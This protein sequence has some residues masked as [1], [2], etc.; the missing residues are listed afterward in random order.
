MR[1]LGPLATGEDLAPLAPILH[2]WMHLL[3]F[4]LFDAA[5]LQGVS[6]PIIPS[7]DRRGPIF[8]SRPTWTWIGPGILMPDRV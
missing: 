1:S 7:I 3:E 4:D 8:I 6:P 2:R 5:A